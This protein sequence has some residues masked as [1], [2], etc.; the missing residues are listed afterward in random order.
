MAQYVEYREGAVVW[1]W[2]CLQKEKCYLIGPDEILGKVGPGMSRKKVKA[3]WEISAGKACY[4]MMT[5]L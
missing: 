3:G 1:V 5:F 4:S 2:G